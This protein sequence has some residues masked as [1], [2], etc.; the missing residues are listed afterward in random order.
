[1]LP[2]GNSDTRDF[3]QTS[4]AM[5]QVIQAPVGHPPGALAPTQPVRL[6]INGLE[7]TLNIA[8]CLYRFHAKMG[9]R[10]SYMLTHLP[11]TEMSRRR[12]PNQQRP[13][14]SRV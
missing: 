4:A 8:P 1:M 9:K 3:H 13:R 5:S 14:M 7:H 11:L 2:V 6:T 10:C 12:R